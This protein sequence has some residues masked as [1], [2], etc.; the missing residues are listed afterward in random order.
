MN[1]AARLI[2]C[3][4]TQHR[5]GEAAPVGPPITGGKADE[6]NVVVRVPLPKGNPPV[7]TP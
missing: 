5:A 2:L 3:S 1:I 6:A 7:P 4:P